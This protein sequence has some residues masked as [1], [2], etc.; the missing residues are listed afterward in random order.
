MPAITKMIKHSTPRRFDGQ[1]LQAQRSK[2]TKQDRGRHLTAPPTRR[3]QRKM[4]SQGRGSHPSPP[5]TIKGCA[6][7]P[8]GESQSSSRESQSAAGAGDAIWRPPS[9]RGHPREASSVR[10]TRAGGQ[11]PT[12]VTTLRS[13]S[14]EKLQNVSVVEKSAQ[15]QSLTPPLCPV[16]VP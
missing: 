12:L 16:A 2:V 4:T 13:G 14:A 3:R 5:P 7:Q 9:V 6:T 8:E 1:K 15:S 11:P 10:P